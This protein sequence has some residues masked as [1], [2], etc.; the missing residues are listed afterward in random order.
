MDAAA[1]RAA[2][3]AAAQRLYMLDAVLEQDEAAAASARQELADTRQYLTSRVEE[4]KK[5]ANICAGL[6]LKC[7]ARQ[8]ALDQADAEEQRLNRSLDAAGSGS[9]CCRSW[10]RIWTA[11]SS[12]SKA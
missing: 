6:A 8:Q 3:E 4:E 11:T 1:A 9:Q 2:S 5:L 12:R 7:Q 10:K